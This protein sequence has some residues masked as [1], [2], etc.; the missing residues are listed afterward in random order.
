MPMRARITPGAGR[1][2][3]GACR[4]RWC[5]AMAATCRRPARRQ[6]L[7]HGR[8]GAVRTPPGPVRSAAGVPFPDTIATPVPPDG[9]CIPDRSRARPWRR[10]ACA[11]SCANDTP[12]C[13]ADGAERQR[14]L[15]RRVDRSGAGDPRHADH[16][17]YDRCRRSSRPAFP[18]T[19]LCVT[20]WSSNCRIIINYPEHIQPLWD[21]A[22]PIT[23]PT[24]GA[25]LSDRHL[26]AGRLPQPDE[27]R[28]RRA[29]ARRAISI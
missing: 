21:L 8:A 10:R 29:D 12:P 26:H 4:A 7:S 13:A 11:V 24:T 5:P 18:T 3:A 15:H 23:G 27:C 16:L 6:P 14:A 22:R 25:V 17:R 2:A 9:A 19:A 28:R 1:V 20:A